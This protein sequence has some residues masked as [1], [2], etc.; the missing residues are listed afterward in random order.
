M[1][2]ELIAQ[3]FSQFEEA[4]YTYKGIECWSARE[5][6]QVLGYTKWNNFYKVIDKAKTAC[7]SS[8]VGTLDHFADVGKMVQLGSSSAR[9]IEDIGL[10]RY[11]NR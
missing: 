3:L 10:T 8:G 9:E 2:K 5:L 7:E 4:A 6:Q 11:A 1:K